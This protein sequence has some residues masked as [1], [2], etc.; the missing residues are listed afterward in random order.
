M[1]GKLQ[2]GKRNR[3]ETVH[4]QAR[5]R[6]HL[7][8]KRSLKPFLTKNR[9]AFVHHESNECSKSELDLFS[10]PPTQTSI[11]KGQWIEYHPLS[12]QGNQVTRSDYS[13]GYTLFAFDLTPDH[14]PGEHFELIK[15]GNLRVELHFA[16]PLAN[17]VNL[18]I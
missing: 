17:T 8:S 12:N 3:Q 2:K 16:Q 6:K 4:L 10:I 11:S 15:H 13:Q 18:I 9:M 5:E 14:C 7:C 1:V